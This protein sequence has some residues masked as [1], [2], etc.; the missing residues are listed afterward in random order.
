MADHRTWQK[1][2]LFLHYKN[3][4]RADL[5]RS[6]IV[7]RV[8]K[9]IA[10]VK[11]ALGQHGVPF[12]KPTN[13]AIFTWHSTTSRRYFAKHSFCI[14]SP[15]DHTAVSVADSHLRLSLGTY[16]VKVPARERPQI[17]TSI[18]VQQEWSGD[19]TLDALLTHA[20]PHRQAAC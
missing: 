6:R 11:F 5:L 1:L 13:A 8:D 14:P 15:T 4:E 9:K 19:K 16:F 17:L 2:R 10:S 7:L 3:R 12:G 18:P 20:A